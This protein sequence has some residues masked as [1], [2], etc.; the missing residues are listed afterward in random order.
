MEISY[1]EPGVSLL[2][3]YTYAAVKRAICMIRVTT[4]RR[5]AGPVIDYI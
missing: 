1:S 5:Y 2:E 3:A 4:I